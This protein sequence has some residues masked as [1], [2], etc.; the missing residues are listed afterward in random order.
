MKTSFINKHNLTAKLIIAQ[1]YLI[2][3]KYFFF[4][5]YKNLIPT[6]KLKNMCTFLSNSQQRVY[7]QNTFFIYHCYL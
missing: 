2:I 4:A 1:L 6:A 5:L 7:S 3:A